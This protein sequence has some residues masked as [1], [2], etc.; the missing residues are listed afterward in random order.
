MISYNK[1][2]IKVSPYSKNPPGKSQD[3]KDKFESETRST[4][5]LLII[6]AHTEGFEFKYINL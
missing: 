3:K 1:N 5:L 4:L 2:D 6:T